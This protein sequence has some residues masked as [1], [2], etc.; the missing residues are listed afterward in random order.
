MGIDTQY[1]LTFHILMV[2]TCQ[3]SLQNT[4]PLPCTLSDVQLTVFDT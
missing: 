4:T 3:S 2:C 1:M